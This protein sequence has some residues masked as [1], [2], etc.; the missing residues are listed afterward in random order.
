VSASANQAVSI[1]TAATA[2]AAATAAD[3]LLRALESVLPPE[4]AAV[5]HQAEGDTAVALV[6]TVFALPF[7]LALLA[8]LTRGYA[9]E[10]SSFVVDDALRTNPL[11]FL[12]DTR[13]E[14][15]RRED[16]VPDL[17]DTQRRKAA[18]VEV[19]P[20]NPAPHTSNPE[21]LPLNLVP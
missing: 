6:A 9:G 14:E 20:Q 21:S 5:V 18:A 8:A 12:I 16:G 2:A 11:A 13:D 17:R 4:F 15:S 7:A 10:Q 19:P 1:V 3:A